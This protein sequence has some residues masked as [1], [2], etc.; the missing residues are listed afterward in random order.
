M[1]NVYYNP[2]HSYFSTGSVLILVLV[3]I[4]TITILSMALAWR[5]RMEIK[6][7]HSFIRRTQAYYLAL[8]GIERAKAHL[9]SKPFAAENMSYFSTLNTTTE[10]YLWSN[11]GLDSSP[12]FDLQVQLRDE[13]SLFNINQSDPASWV[14]TEPVDKEMAET[15]LDWIDSDNQTEPQGAE[16]GYYQQLD[17]PY[18]AK[19]SPMLYL[20]ELLYLKGVSRQ[21]YSRKPDDSIEHTNLN[22]SLIEF[23]TVYGP[24]TIN[25]NTASESILEALPGLNEQA[26]NTIINFRVGPDQQLGT[27]DDKVFQEPQDFELLDRLSGLQQELLKQYSHFESRHFR[28]FSQATVAGNTTC[29]LLATLY[30]GDNDIELVSMEQ[31]SR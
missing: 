5:V 22:S 30:I 17:P 11:L 19:N 7:T 15:I 29:S 13:E 3:V 9:V 20:R 31:L 8:S 2:R 24:G 16:S 25:I 10:E 26:A 12:D 27:E 21:H 28:I 18:Q 23:F 1:T 4:A 6:I 14:K